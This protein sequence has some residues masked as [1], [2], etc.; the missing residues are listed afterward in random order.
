MAAVETPTEFRAEAKY[1]RTAP[2][3]AQLVVSEIRGLPVA[4]A[5]TVLTFMTRAAARDVAKVLASAVANA[6]SHPGLQRRGPRRLGGR[7][8][9][10]SD[11]EA[12]AGTRPRP[13]R[14]DQEADVPH[15][16]PPA[17]GRARGDDAARCRR[18][19]P[20]LP[21]RTRRAKAEAPV[22]PATRGVCRA[23]EPEAEAVSAEVEAPAE[24]KPKPARTRRRPQPKPETRRGRRGGRP[25]RR[26][27][28]PRA[29]AR[30]RSL[31]RRPTRRETAEKPKR[32]SRKKRGLRAAKGRSGDERRDDSQCGRRRQ[33]VGQKVHPGGLRVGIIHDWK[34]NWY[35]GAK[36][37]PRY[38]ME[39]VKIRDHIVG[40][41]QPRGALGHPHR[42]GQAADQ[43]RHLHGAARDRHRQ[44]GR[45]GRRASPR[46]SRAH[47]EERPHQH[48]RDQ[49]A[50]SSTRS[51]SP[52]PWRSSS[53]TGSASAAR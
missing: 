50:R 8:R 43:D 40:Q 32:A 23:G 17:D 31:P 53:R 30:R 2:R 48:Q 14:P 20:R 15:H 19:R 41:A 21:K 11:P 28:R 26:S 49:A 9:L 16:H 45:R 4:E 44:V 24:E 39:D 22:A 5:R 42:E 37:F 7:R 29:R 25:P 12:L 10:R 52:S 13:R 51:S 3:K 35:T 38:L 36:E 18:P 6:E 27:R 46:G 1:V 34:S 47:P 33:L